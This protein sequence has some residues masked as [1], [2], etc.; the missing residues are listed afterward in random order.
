MKR[1]SQFEGQALTEDHTLTD[2]TVLAAGASRSLWDDRA[3]I[4]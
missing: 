4:L 1:E 3:L 2:G